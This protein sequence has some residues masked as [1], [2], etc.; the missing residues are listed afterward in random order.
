MRETIARVLHSTRTVYA[1]CLVSLVLGLAFIFV[2][3]PHPWGWAGIDAYHVLALEL[4]RGGSFST[5]DVPWG[6]AYFVAFWYWLSGERLWVPLVAQVVANA[7]VPLLLYHLVVPLAGRRTAV[8]SAVL[9]GAFSFNTLYASTQAS[10]AICT[11]LFTAG[12]LYFARGFRSGRALDFVLGGLFAGLAPQFRPNLILLPAVAAAFYLWQSPRS[13]RAWRNVALYLVV[14]IAVLSPWTIRNYRLTGILMPTST[15]GGQQL[16]YGSLQVGAHLESQS[17]NPRRAFEFAAFDYTSLINTSLI[18]SADPTTCVGRSQ[19]EV[20]LIYWTDRDSQQHRA[21]ARAAGR[22]LEFE[23]PGQPAD[24]V[25][26]YFFEGSWADTADKVATPLPGA[27]APYVTFVSSDHLGD[28]DRHNDLLDIF[29]VARLMRELAWGDRPAAPGLL[30]LNQD[31]ITD[32]RDLAASVGCLLQ[33]LP[34]QAPPVVQF[35]ASASRATL[36]L[37]DGSTLSVPRDFGGRQTDLEAQGELAASLVAKSRSFAAIAAAGVSAT[38]HM[39]HV[40]DDVRVNDVYY[41]KEPHR[42][43]RYTALAFDNISR[44]PVEFALAAAYRFVRMFIIVGTDD[45]ATT[46]QFSWSRLAYGAGQ[47]LST[48][49]LV[50]FIAGI[51]VAVRQRSAV[52]GLLLPIFYVPVTICFVLTNMRYTVTVQPLMFVFVA[53]A[54]VAWLRLDPPA[55]GGESRESDASRLLKNS[56]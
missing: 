8:L 49:Y 1:A 25:V 2:W 56:A 24:T 44:T 23:I 55:A 31:G 38:P 33:P 13:G 12:L 40:V 16:W 45:V 34:R 22:R 42:L 27:R 52:L 51:V 6:Y 37:P 26:Y 10:D 19:P 53:V 28:L 35:D 20:K 7:G 36:T 32:Q 47:A 18:V 21:A 48:I 9:V 46:Q 15:H 39:C 29:D 11:V 4:A 30:D 3:A 17:H 5:T 14:V 43:N 41:R 54:L 50:V